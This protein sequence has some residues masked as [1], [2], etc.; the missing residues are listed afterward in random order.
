MSH[1]AS[2]DE[3]LSAV[4][5]ERVAPSGGASAALA[6]A[7]AAALAEMACIHTGDPDG[8]TDLAA[9]REDLRARRAE[10][11]DLRERDAA[12][13]AELF[14]DADKPPTAEDVERATAVPLATAEATVAVL[15]RTADVVAAGDRNPVVDAAVGVYLAHAALQ[16]ALFVVRSNLPWIDDHETVAG[17]HEQAADL[18]RAG[19]A[20]RDRAI[21]ALQQRFPA[22]AFGNA[23]DPP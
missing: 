23:S 21:E 5:S 18:E 13:V 20:A 17:L 12:V 7:T 6:G 16:G 4:A 15:E 3:F 2:I 8:P 19:T 11:L 9:A 14:E 10:L 1:D 22:D